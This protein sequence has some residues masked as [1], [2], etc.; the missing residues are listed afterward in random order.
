MGWMG[1]GEPCVLYACG[2]GDGD[3]IFRYAMRSDTGTRD[4][5]MWWCV[6]VV[7]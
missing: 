3:A 5:L 1:V 4:V 2:D 6:M 7:W